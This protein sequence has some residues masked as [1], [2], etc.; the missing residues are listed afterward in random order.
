[1]SS[2]VKVLED[3]NKNFK[4]SIKYAQASIAKLLQKLAEA[5]S[6]Q[7]AATSELKAVKAR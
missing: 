4:Q 2:R 1:M 3:E 5:C 6:V 7:E